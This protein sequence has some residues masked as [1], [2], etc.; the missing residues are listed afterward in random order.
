MPVEDESSASADPGDMECAWG[1]VAGSV[2]GLVKASW[3]DARIRCWREVVKGSPSISGDAD[4]DGDMAACPAALDVEGDDNGDIP[5]TSTAS[6]HLWAVGDVEILKAPGG[7][8]V[9]LPNA[10]L[11]IDATPIALSESAG[12]GF[13]VEMDAVEL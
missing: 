3:T 12:E 8:E 4:K 2:N 13:G 11:R 5:A 10:C 1:G 7:R 6:I 9:K